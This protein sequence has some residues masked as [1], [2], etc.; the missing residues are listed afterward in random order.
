MALSKPA[1]VESSLVLRDFRALSARG[2][3][4]CSVVGV[5]ASAGEMQVL[6]EGVPELSFVL[7]DEHGQWIS[8]TLCGERAHSGVSAGDRVLVFGARRVAPPS[9]GGT[10]RLWIFEDGV[11]RVL[12]EGLV[13]PRRRR[14][15]PNGGTDVNGR[16]AAPSRRRA[17]G[18][19]GPVRRGR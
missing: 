4:T 9:S 5:V 16:P 14:A 3:Y 18:R 15:I 6:A 1:P 2:L 11:L 10:V 19:G 7:V 12:Q 13:P 8:C 17:S